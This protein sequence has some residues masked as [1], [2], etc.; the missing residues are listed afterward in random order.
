MRKLLIL[1]PLFVACNNG[2]SSSS[3][4]ATVQ[5]DTEAVQNAAL[6]A[7]AA[8]GDTLQPNELGRIPILEYHLIGDSAARWMRKRGEFRNDLEKLY[9]RGYRPV[10]M[11]D[12]VDKKID[13]PR[14]LSPV[15]FVFDD[16]SPSQFKYIE[17]NG[18]LEIDPSSGLGIWLDFAK[19]HPDW[20]N[21]AVF[22]VLSGAEAGRS[23]FGDKGIEGQKSEWRHQKI[24]F[25]ADQGFEICNHTLWHAQLS[26][27]PDAFVQEQIARLQLAVDSAVPGY[28]I[29][30]LALPLG[31]WPKNRELAHKGSW[32]DP[33]SKRTITYNYDAVLEV[34]GGPARSPYDAAFNGH[35]L[36]RVQA[37]DPEL[38][39]TIDRL[40][41]NK[42]RYVS[43]GK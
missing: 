27:Y 3:N 13:L 5:S 8:A 11:A 20:K 34:A 6:P 19:Q 14:G 39:S 10:N 12:V 23:F 21:K 32:T 9:A 29:R 30:T 25:L 4:N 22:C 17:Q 18:K 1:L 28:R 43:D 31:L 15:V 42:T 7:T 24:R 35:K 2:S 41:K 26:K 16:A 36:P 40:D 37:I 33:K 38:W